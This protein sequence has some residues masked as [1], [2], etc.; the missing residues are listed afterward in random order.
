MPNEPRVTKPEARGA[1]AVPTT[2]PNRR[3]STKNPT[4]GHA[5]KDA[6]F[7]FWRRIIHRRKARK[8]ALLGSK[9]FAACV[10]HSLQ[11]LREST[12]E[13][14]SVGIDFAAVDFNT[15]ELIVVGLG[16]RPSN[17]FLVGVDNVVQFHRSTQSILVEH[18]GSIRRARCKGRRRCT[19]LSQRNWLL[20]Q[21]S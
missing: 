7:P 1:S 20:A 12:P 17:A 5:H 21:T 14:L 6:L 2:A 16:Q 11:E 8:D 3:L 19:H 18:G 13:L 10:V 9:S 15:Q 4:S